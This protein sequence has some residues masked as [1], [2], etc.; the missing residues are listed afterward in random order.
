M[1]EIKLTQAHA[2]VGMFIE[3]TAADGQMDKAELQTVG[4]LV[5]FFLEPNGFDADARKKI[6]QNT[7][8]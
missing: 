5:E 8:F 6:I 4:G 1:S 7:K 2:L 3:M